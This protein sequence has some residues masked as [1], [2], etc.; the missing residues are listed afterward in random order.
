MAAE[1]WFFVLAQTALGFGDGRLP[2]V[3]WVMHGQQGSRQL[4]CQQHHGL[5]SY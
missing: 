5:Q 4:V 1:S 2:G 3:R